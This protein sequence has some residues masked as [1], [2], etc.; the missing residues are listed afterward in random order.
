MLKNEINY[1]EV[2]KFLKYN[3]DLN[4]QHFFAKALEINYK[5]IEELINKI[6]KNI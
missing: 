6:D 5:K 1:K 2:V 4:H 3:V